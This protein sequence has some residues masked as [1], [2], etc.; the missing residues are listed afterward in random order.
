MFNE[1]LLPT[2]HR[3]RH[4]EKLEFRMRFSTDTMVAMQGWEIKRERGA[5]HTHLLILLMGKV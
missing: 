1:Y 4:K 3:S 2:K 5:S